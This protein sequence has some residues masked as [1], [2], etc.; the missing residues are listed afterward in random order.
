[1]YFAKEATNTI[2]N[3]FINKTIVYTLHDEFQPRSERTKRAHRPLLYHIESG[4]ILN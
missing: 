2:Y 3:Y 1:M 4:K